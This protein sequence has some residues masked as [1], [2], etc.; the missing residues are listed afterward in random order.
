VDALGVWA[1][2]QRLFFQ[3]DELPKS[4]VAKLRGI[5]F[6]FDGKMADLLRSEITST[7][8]AASTGSTCECCL[9]YLNI[10]V[11]V[12]VSVFM[13]LLRSETTSADTSAAA[14]STCE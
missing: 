1:R 11:N 5:D 7:D 2:D 14:G 12:C 8:A 10:H 9:R 4:R 6:C 13:D 3:R